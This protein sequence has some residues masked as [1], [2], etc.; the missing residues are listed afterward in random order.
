MEESWIRL[1]HKCFSISAS[2]KSVWLARGA[3]LLYACTANGR[4]VEILEAAERIALPLISFAGRR[5][6]VLA[7]PPWESRKGPVMYFP[8]TANEILEAAERIALPLISSAGRRLAVL[9]TPPQVVQT[10]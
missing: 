1:G 6:A 3:L 2:S 10:S 4:D 9:A 8:G 7:T 5:L